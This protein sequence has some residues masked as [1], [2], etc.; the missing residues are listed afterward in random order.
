MRVQTSTPIISE[1]Q[2]N[3]IMLASISL[4]IS[5]TYLELIPKI[6][7]DNLDHE[8]IV[9]IYKQYQAAGSEFVGLEDWLIDTQFEGK[10][11]AEGVAERKRLEGLGFKL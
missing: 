9:M 3:E 11:R 4:G 10:S 6:T 5:A 7:G 8:E 2:Q 1:D